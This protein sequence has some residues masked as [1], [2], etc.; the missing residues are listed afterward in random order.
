MMV[1]GSLIPAVA[2]FSLFSNNFLNLNTYSVLKKVFNLQLF[3]F[4]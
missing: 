1:Y 4:S 3:D 2:L